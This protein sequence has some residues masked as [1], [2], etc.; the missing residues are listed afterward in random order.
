MKQGTLSAPVFY[1]C[2]IFVL[3][4][5]SPSYL[6][7][8]SGI[9]KAKVQLKNPCSFILLMLF[10]LYSF[11]ADICTIW[12]CPGRQGYRPDQPS[13]NILPALTSSNFNV[14]YHRIKAF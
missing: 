2:F 13:Q 9:R 11:Q 4:L 5:F 14:Y 3:S 10:Y 12:N 1:L 8:T 6:S 7:M